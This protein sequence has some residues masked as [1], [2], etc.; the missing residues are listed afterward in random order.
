MPRL[1]KVSVMR[2]LPILLI[3]L[4]LVCSTSLVA[5]DDT[6]PYTKGNTIADHDIK[7]W[8]NPPAWNEFSDLKGDV[9]VF[10]KWGCT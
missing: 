3:A 1:I 9:V 8:V 2:H 4:I 6:K 7:H 5:Q 10:K